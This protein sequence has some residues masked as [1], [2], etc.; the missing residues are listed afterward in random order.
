MSGKQV[1]VV[2]DEEDILELVRLNLSKEGYR[3]ECAT[4][5]E[6]AIEAS[7]RPILNRLTIFNG[8]VPAAT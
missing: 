1:L 2:D 5:G 3:A 6:A 8:S 7:G 4:T